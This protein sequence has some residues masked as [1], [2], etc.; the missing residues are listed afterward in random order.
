VPDRSLRRTGGHA[1]AAALAVATVAAALAGCG[2]GDGTASSNAG[3]STTT[4]TT[5]GTTQASGGGPTGLTPS[6]ARKVAEAVLASN[7]PADACGRYVTPHYLDV[8]YGGR[9]GCVQAQTPGSSA[10]SLRSFRIVKEGTQGSIAIATAVPNGGPYD[11][12]K[13]TIRLIGGSRGYQV[14]ALHSDVPVGP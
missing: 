6:G 9:A 1:G 7:D 8:A 2:G 14:D 3:A 5:P 11:G 4:A 10:R 13:V 12:S